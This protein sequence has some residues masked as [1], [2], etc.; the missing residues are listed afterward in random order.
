M[1]RIFNFF[2]SENELFDNNYVRTRTTVNYHHP[3]FP[4]FKDITDFIKMLGY[5]NIPYLQTSYYVYFVSRGDTGN[6]SVQ[7]G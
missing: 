7:E 5:L 4:N 3:K 1:C 6:V 2:Q